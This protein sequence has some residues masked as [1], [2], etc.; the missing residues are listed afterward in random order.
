HIHPGRPYDKLSLY[1]NSPEHPA[2][3][4]FMVL[5]SLIP[6]LW[7]KIMDKRIAGKSSKRKARQK[8]NLPY[9][10]GIS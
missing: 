2:G 4:S 9:L 3:Y 7:C 1:D 5:L 8:K 6:P 10:K